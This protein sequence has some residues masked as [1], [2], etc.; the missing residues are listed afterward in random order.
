[1]RPL[2]EFMMTVFRYATC[3]CARNANQNTIIYV[4]VLPYLKGY[5]SALSVLSSFPS[6][7]P[8]SSLKCL[9]SL[10]QP[11]RFSRIRV[12]SSSVRDVIFFKYSSAVP[13]VSRII[14]SVACIV[15]LLPTERRKE[16]SYVYVWI[17]DANVQYN[18]CKKLELK[19]DPIRYDHAL[20]SRDLFTKEKEIKKK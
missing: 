11:L 4:Q 10:S 5:K 3:T 15:S 17:L 12:I 6:F 16:V 18:G 9:D 8:G 14:T 20:R 7:Q 13:Q 19:M 2:L 1:M